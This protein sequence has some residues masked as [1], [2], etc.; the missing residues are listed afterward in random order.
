M[1]HMINGVPHVVSFE[2]TDRLKHEV[3]FNNPEHLNPDEMLNAIL[4]AWFKAQ[5]C[6]D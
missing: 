4:E 2:N 5:D 1:K 6:K 3:A